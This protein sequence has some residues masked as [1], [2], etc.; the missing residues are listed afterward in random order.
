[1]K[2]LAALIVVLSIAPPCTAQP[3]VPAT[4]RPVLQELRSGFDRETLGATEALTTVKHGL[5][6]WLNR[7]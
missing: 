1:M 3:A 4:L 5:R 6:D 2:T 7:S